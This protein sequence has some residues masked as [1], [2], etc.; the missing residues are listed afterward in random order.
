MTSQQVYQKNMFFIGA[1]WNWSA[2]ILFV[3]L[4]YLSQEH[5]AM[6]I[7]IP[8]QPLW[9]FLTFMAVAIFGLGYYFVSRDV[10]RNR[11]IIKMGCIG[12]AMI[13][14]MFYIYWQKGDLSTMSFCLI[15]GDAIF[16]V[17]FAQV[18]YTLKKN[19]NQ[20]AY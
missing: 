18:L 6:M 16:T 14:I 13:F 1:V 20:V 11:D 4:Y 12:K 5:L 8:E 7:K 19:R 9:F 2:A 17:L 15:T 10:E 3:G